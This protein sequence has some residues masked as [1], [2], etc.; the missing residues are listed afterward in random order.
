VLK[1]THYS[2][3][4]FDR[5]LSISARPPAHQ[6]A[7]RYAARMHACRRPRGRIA[8]AYARRGPHN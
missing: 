3:L 2:R 7:M 4:T 5:L 1:H 8:P 6:S